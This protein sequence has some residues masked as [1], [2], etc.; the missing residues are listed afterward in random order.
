MYKGG[1]VSVRSFVY[2][3]CSTDTNGKM[4]GQMTGLREVKR[5]QWV[6]N[7]FV[8]MEGGERFVA[9]TLG[10][11]RAVGKKLLIGWVLD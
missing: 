8:R 9:A 6:T 2:T 3:D 5:R 11:S 7:S 4:K 10:I 1:D